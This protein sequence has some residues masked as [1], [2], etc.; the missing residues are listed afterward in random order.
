MLFGTDMHDPVT[1]TGTDIPSGESVDDIELDG[2]QL[3]D[4]TVLAGQPVPQF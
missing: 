1:D 4:Q 2:D 3:R